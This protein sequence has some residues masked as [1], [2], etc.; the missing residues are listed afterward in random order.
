MF[1]A[2][3]IMAFVFFIWAGGFIMESM[4]ELR[5]IKHAKLVRS[6]QRHPAGKAR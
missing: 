3:L 5:Q 1:E 2:S 4:R 6:I